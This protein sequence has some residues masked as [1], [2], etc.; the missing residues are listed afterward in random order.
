MIISELSWLDCSAGSKLSSIEMFSAA[1]NTWTYVTDMPGNAKLGI[2]AAV[3]GDALVLIG[4]YDKGGG[5]DGGDISGDVQRFNILTNRCAALCDD[6]LYTKQFVQHPYNI[7]S[8]FLK[9]N[10]SCFD[11]NKCIR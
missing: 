2:A 10:T 7:Y 9:S 6:L 5:Q 11:I 1:H 8:M 4:G 3:V